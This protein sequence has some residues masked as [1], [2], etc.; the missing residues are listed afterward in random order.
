MMPRIHFTFLPDMNDT[1]CFAIPMWYFGE[2]EIE[3]EEE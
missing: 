2:I 3:I 1:I